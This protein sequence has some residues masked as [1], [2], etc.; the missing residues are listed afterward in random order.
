MVKKKINK[1]K[2]NN[3]TIRQKSLNNKS[4]K[5]LYY[6]IREKGKKP[7]YFKVKEGITVDNY[8]MAYYGKVKIKKKGVVQYNKETPANKYL[9]KVDIR[10]GRI[11]NLIEK[12]ITT[13]IVS[14]LKVL[15]RK[16]IHNTYIKM[17][18]PLVKDKELLEILAT[19][20]NIKKFKQRIQTSVTVTSKEEGIRFELR[21]FNKTLEEVSNDFKEIGK[22][23]G[24][25][26]GDI[27]KILNKG[28]KFTG[29]QQG[30]DMKDYEKNFITKKIDSISVRL[31]F[32]KGR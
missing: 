7:A 5:G 30:F 24:I 26:E 25:F 12:G 6:Y 14:N 32:V 17:L 18:K 9:R 11:D 13:N 19:E 28:Y 15:D 27:Q 20:E 21:I 4:R 1:Q 2:D 29:I 22:K 10:G 31:R 16:M 8:L 23:E 3:I